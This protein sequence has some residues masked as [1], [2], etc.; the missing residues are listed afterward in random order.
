MIN[1]LHIVCNN[2]VH[3]TERYVI[4]IIKSID[5]N[6][7]SISVATPS[8]GPLSLILK[9]MEVEEIIYDNDKMNTFTMMGAIKLLKKIYNRNFHVIHGNAGI[10]PNIIGKFLGVKLNIES[11]HG[12]LFSEEVLEN[13]TF[14]MK[15]HEKIKEYFVDFFIAE[16]E[17]DKKKMIKYFDINE[18]KIKVI[19]NGI[20]LNKTISLNVDSIDSSN[21][22]TKE[23][24]IGT[25]GRLTFQKGHDILIKAFKS[26]IEVSRKV[27]LIIMGSGE[28]EKN[29]MKMITDFGLNESVIIKKYNENFND[30]FK[31]LDVFILTSRFEGVPY[32]LLE[33]M[34]NKIPIIATRVGGIDNILD[35]GKTGLLI[36]KENIKETESALLKLV[37]DTDLRNFLSSNAFK[38][39]QKYSLESTVKSIEKLYIS[40]VS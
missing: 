38:E 13:M 29:L 22:D 27:K 34:N 6:I 20:N 39:V 4:D 25:I 5:R 30:F 17:N 40:A 19:Y 12:I 28:Q 2:V 33:A 10:I 3:G 1:V 37:V 14:I 35:D 11:K 21:K 36:E 26:V 31:K 15:Y 16:S 18:K 8:Y 9:E 24:V 7:F 32:V 23:I